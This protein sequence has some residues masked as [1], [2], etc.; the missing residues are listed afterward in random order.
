MKI[1]IYANC[2]GGAIKETLGLHNQSECTYIPCHDTDI[3]SEEFTKLIK[4]SDIIITQPIKD[5]YRETH[6]L[7]TNY[8]IENAKSDASII[9]FDSC[10]FNFYHFDLTYKMYNGTIL[11]VPHDYHYNGIITTYKNAQSVEHYISQ[12]VNNI[13]LKTPIE[14]EELAHHSLEELRTRF[15]KNV[16]NYGKRSNVSI[17][18]TYNFIKTNF[19][20][21]L[22]F[23]SMNHPAPSVIQYIC[24]EIIK[25]VPLKCTINYTIDLLGAYKGILYK[26]IQPVVRFN[27]EDYNPL[28]NGTHEITDIVNYYVLAYKSLDINKL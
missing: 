15:N 18:S 2:Q 6:Y 4:E 24:E 20:D 19:K 22:L 13:T 26:C 8:I 21:K 27:I 7:S 1:L 14:L 28:I 16:E 3:I 9:L 10:Y 11:Q 17:I 25:I 23:Y 5:D 12:Y